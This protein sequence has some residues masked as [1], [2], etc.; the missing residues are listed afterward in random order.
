MELRELFA[1][2]IKNY[3]GPD[4]GQAARVPL[5]HVP[6]LVFCS[7]HRNRCATAPTIRERTGLSTNVGNCKLSEPFAGGLDHSSTQS[8][9]GCSASV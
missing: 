4:G 3:M 6:L 8:V 7:D 5:S 9:C 2:F 1:R